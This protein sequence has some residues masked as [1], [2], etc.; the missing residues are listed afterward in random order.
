MSHHHENPIELQVVPD[1][2][3]GGNV[4]DVR[5]VECATEYACSHYFSHMVLRESR[6]G[7]T[8]PLHPS[9]PSRNPGVTHVISL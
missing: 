9:R 1:L 2:Q 7:P 3:C 4:A 6:A 5:W 8:N